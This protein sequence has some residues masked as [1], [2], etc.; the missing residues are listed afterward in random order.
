MKSVCSLIWALFF[1]ERVGRRWSLVF[2]AFEMGIVMLI[3]GIVYV[4]SGV[5]ALQV[6]LFL[7]PVMP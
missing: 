7:E 4:S 3:I 6:V 5:E 2:G 1:I